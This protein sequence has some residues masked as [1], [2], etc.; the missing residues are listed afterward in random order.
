MQK[1]ISAEKEAS[2]Q[3]DRK[4]PEAGSATE[5]ARQ[6]LEHNMRS[7]EE[8]N[9]KLNKQLEELDLGSDND[10]EAAVLDLT[11]HI[12]S[13]WPNL[14]DGPYETRLETLRSLN[15]TTGSVLERNLGD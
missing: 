15:L 3:N 8:T 6:E 5:I 13:N 2:K 9:K 11:A 7:V 10:G 4:S 12:A 14:L 1:T